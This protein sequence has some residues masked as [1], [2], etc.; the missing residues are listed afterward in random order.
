MYLVG[1]T[2]GDMNPIYEAIELAKRNNDY[3]VHVG[4]LGVGFIDEI[5][6][7][8]NYLFNEG[9]CFIRGNHDN[10]EKC[11]LMK[12]YLGDYGFF[13]LS[14]ETG[15]FFV[16]GALSIDK[17]MRRMLID[18]WPD[19][20]LPYHK[21][22]DAFRIYSDIKPRIMITHD[23]PDFV[24]SNIHGSTISS[25]T[26][27]AFDHFFGSHKPDVWIFG[28]HHISFDKMLYGTR[29]ICLA[30]NEIRYIDINSI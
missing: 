23:C 16:S 22:L 27:K 17:N 11:Y 28:H 12:S 7:E 15:F 20:E 18:W 19:E 30:I 25:S 8:G 6:K 5:E 9:F 2:H 24:I 21:M 26:S 29:F 14:N 13:D 10:P 1:D 4:D 3:V